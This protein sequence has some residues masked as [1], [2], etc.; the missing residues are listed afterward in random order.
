MWGETAAFHFFAITLSN[1][2]QF[3]YVRADVYYYYY[4]YYYYVTSEY[5]KKRNIKQIVGNPLNL[6]S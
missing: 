3:R 1:L 6:C 5:K 4:N 2:A